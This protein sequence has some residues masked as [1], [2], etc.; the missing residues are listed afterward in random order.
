MLAFPSDFIR[1]SIGKMCNIKKQNV[2][3]KFL[4]DSESLEDATRIRLACEEYCSW[5][6]N[7]WGCSIQCSPSCQWNAISE[8]GSVEDWNG[9]IEGDIT[10]KPGTQKNSF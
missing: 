8:C 5:R 4:L 7:C 2:L 9:M 1:S 10:Q 6:E 3:K